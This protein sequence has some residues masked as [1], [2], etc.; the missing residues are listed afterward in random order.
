MCSKTVFAIQISAKAAHGESIDPVT[1]LATT[2]ASVADPDILL[3]PCYFLRPHHPASISS[4]SHLCYSPSKKNN[5]ACRCLRLAREPF[6]NRAFLLIASWA[7][8]S[9]LLHAK[10]ALPKR[11]VKET[12]RLMAEP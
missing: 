1:L 7:K 6:R 2:P 5:T 4:P 8:S 3:G 11:I 9:G 12:E 10:M